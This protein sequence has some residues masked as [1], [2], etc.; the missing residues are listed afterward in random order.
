MAV[1]INQH[2]GSA[3]SVHGFQR[4][5]AKEIETTAGALEA[6]QRPQ[7]GLV[8]NAFF[9]CD[10]N[11]RRGVQGVV[12]TRRIQ[13][14]LQQLFILTCQGEMPLRTNLFVTFHP[15]IGIFAETV[16]RDLTAHARQQ[17]ADH[18]VVYTHDGPSI[19]RQIVEKV[20]KCL[21]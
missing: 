12:T 14:Y 7:N 8:I 21:L 6:F 4:E 19:K 15:N 3:F 18:R 1:V 11:G 10:R 5:L 16:G 9:C 17:F 20:Y 2:R 13:R